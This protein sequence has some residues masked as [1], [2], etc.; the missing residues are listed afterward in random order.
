MTLRTYSSPPL[1]VR[2][3]KLINLD[4]RDAQEMTSTRVWRPLYIVIRIISTPD[5]VRT[6]KS[7]KLLYTIRALEIN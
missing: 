1:P 5:H 7:E 2:E 6:R 4:D 3:R